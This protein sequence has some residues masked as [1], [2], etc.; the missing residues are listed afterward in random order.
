MRYTT[1]WEFVKALPEYPFDLDPCAERDTS[2]ATAF[3]SKD[4]DGLCMPWSGKVFCNPPYSDPAAWIRKALQER[5]RCKV[6][7]MLLKSDTGTKW[8]HDLLLPNADVEFLRGRIR[9]NGKKDA[10]YPCLLARFINT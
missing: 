2:K 7:V 1:P 4:N 8:F 5:K 3:W 6:I 10:P 9:F